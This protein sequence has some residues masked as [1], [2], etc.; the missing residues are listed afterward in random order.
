MG[1]EYT[2]RQVHVA[3]RARVHDPGVGVLERH[4]V[5]GCDEAGLI[6]HL[7]G[8]DLRRSECCVSL[9]VGAENP[10]SAPTLP[11][12][13]AIGPPALA[14]LPGTA[15]LL[16]RGTLGGVR[17][18]ADPGS[19]GMELGALLSTS[20][21]LLGRVL[22]TLVAL[23]LGRAAASAAP[24]LAVAAVATYTKEERQQGLVQ[25][26]VVEATRAVA[27]VFFASLARRN[28]LRE[29][30]SWARMKDE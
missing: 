17:V 13:V 20:T 27:A 7:R 9:R 25:Q 12:T 11:P 29:S 19:H 26:E 22:T 23:L 10:W 15:S 6:P 24:A 3:S 21:V 2:I 14:A 4:L 30:S 8:G 28:S 16:T 5:Q 18:E 1:K